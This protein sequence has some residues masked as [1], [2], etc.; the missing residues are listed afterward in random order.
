MSEKLVTKLTH[1]T[2]WSTAGDWLYDHTMNAGDWLYLMMCLALVA[3]L[4]WDKRRHR[5]WARAHATEMAHRARSH[6]AT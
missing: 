1:P 2:Q 6:K 4:T 3:W 5:Q